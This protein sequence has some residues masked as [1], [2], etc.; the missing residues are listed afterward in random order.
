[1]KK[2]IIVLLSVLLISCY[3]EQPIQLKPHIEPKLVVKT[4]YFSLTYAVGDSIKSTRCLL[5]NDSN[6]IK[7][8][9]VY[10]FWL[11]DNY[12]TEILP[13]GSKEDNFYMIYKYDSLT[14]NLEIEIPK[15]KTPTRQL[16]FIAH[17]YGTINP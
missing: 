11:V 3:K 16:Q 14:N 13:Y 12:E 1:M 5:L 6:I 4:F 9:S 7:V 15:R 2:I 17:L 8:D 10:V